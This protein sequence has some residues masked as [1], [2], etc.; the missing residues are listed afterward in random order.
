LGF[1]IGHRCMAPRPSMHLPSPLYQNPMKPLIK[2]NDVLTKCL[3]DL[4]SLVQTCSSAC[5]PAASSR[6]TA[7]A[8][9]PNSQ[10]A[11]ALCP[12]IK[13][14]EDPMKTQCS[15]PMK[16][17]M[18]FR[19]RQG[20][21]TPAAARAARQRP[22]GRPPAA[23]APPAAASACRAPVHTWMGAFI[24]GHRGAQG[25]GALKPGAATACMH[26]RL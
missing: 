4:T 1:N 19:I 26:G 7:S 13:P 17:F 20:P 15:N 2:T 18:A 11:S 21:Y 24:V 25:P 5:R 9:R 6:E 22:P 16:S 8:K 23:A 10:H 12:V 14:N 3:Y